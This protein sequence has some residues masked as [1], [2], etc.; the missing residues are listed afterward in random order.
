M[1]TLKQFT[2][3]IENP[4]RI[5]LIMDFLSEKLRGEYGQIKVSEAMAAMLDMEHMRNEWRRVPP[6]RQMRAL[7]FSRGK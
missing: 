1:E 7:A 5:V 2:P 4:E 3:D 6:S